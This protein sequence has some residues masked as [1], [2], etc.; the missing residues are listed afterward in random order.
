MHGYFRKLRRIY[1]TEKRKRRT[2]RMAS[3]TANSYPNAY[4]D[5]GKYIKRSY[6]SNG[7]GS[8]AKLLKRICSKKTRKAAN[9]ANYGGYKKS[10]DFH[11]ELW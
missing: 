10:Y 9:L 7:K 5:N 3:A 4:W 2:K 1:N 11:W 8:R 6:Q